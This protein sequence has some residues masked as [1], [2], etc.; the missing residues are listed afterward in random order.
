MV[1]MGMGMVG[2]AIR[3]TRPTLSL[4]IWPRV[5]CPFDAQGGVLEPL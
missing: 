3:I 2:T 4:V 1:G 5:A